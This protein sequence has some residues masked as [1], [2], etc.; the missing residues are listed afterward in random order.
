MINTKRNILLKSAIVLVL[1]FFIAV[2]LQFKIN[3]NKTR[4]F[5]LLIPFL[6]FLVNYLAL[7]SANGKSSIRNFSTQILALFGIKFFVFFIER[8]SI[9]FRPH[10]LT[11]ATV[12]INSISVLSSNR[13]RTPVSA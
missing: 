4:W 11:R 1:A 2:V 6:T 12:S 7:L 5:F 9:K 13:N 3:P 10:F 8:I